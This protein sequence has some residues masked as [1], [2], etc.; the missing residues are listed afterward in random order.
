MY[1]AA[2]TWRWAVCTLRGAQRAKIT[3]HTSIEAIVD[4]DKNNY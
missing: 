3:T 4:G 2:E 1:R